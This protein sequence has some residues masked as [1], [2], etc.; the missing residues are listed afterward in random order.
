VCVCE[1]ERERE[2][3]GE[4]KREYVCMCVNKQAR[5]GK[6]HSDVIVQN[7]WNVRS[8]LNHTLHGFRN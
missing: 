4:K 1:R 3:E 6:K 7:K 2:K 5:E 8:N